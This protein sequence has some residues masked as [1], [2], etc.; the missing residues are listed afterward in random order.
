MPFDSIRTT[1]KILTIFLVVVALYVLKVL[2][3]IFVPFMFAVFIALVYAL[4]DGFI[5]EV[6]RTGDDCGYNDIVVGLYGLKIPVFGQKFCREKYFT[7]KSTKN[8][9]WLLPL[10]KSSGD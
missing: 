4:I 10:C 5:N 9:D 1:N 2:S 3:F 7:R 6:A 8:L